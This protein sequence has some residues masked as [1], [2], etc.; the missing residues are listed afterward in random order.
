VAARPGA[1]A[2]GE[3]ERRLVRVGPGPSQP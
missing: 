3:A 1:S 2:E